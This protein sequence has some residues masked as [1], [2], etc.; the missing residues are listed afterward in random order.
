MDIICVDMWQHLYMNCK[1]YI[2][3]SLSYILHEN[4]YAWFMAALDKNV[5]NLT[6]WL[7]S[8]IFI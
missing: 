1:L 6:V 5:K 3:S 2:L 8:W 7:L 4:S